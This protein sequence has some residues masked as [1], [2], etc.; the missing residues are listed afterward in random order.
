[1]LLRTARYG[2]APIIKAGRHI[3]RSEQPFADHHPIRMRMPVM[4]DSGIRRGSD[5]LQEEIG[6][7]LVLTGCPKFSELNSAFLTAV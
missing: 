7:S 2:T 6:T 4:L 3:R 1:M 5:I